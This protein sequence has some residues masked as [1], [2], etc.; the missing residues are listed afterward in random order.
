MELYTSVYRG[1]NDWYFT[2]SGMADIRFASTGNRNMR[3]EAAIEFYPIDLSGG[4]SVAAVP[5]VSLKR[6]WFKANF[7][8]WRLTAGKTKLA[9]GNGSIF[10]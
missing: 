9:W 4:S 6:L 1:Q 5:A 8:Q 7:P 10:K 3:A 2:G